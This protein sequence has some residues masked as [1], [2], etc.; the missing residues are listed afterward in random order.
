[1]SSD[2]IV[3]TG[4]IQV[5]YSIRR[6]EIV[7]EGVVYDWILSYGEDAEEWFETAE[8][9]EENLRSRYGA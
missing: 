7:D 5:E 4:V 8:Q 6:F 9:A 1:M 3:K 2:V